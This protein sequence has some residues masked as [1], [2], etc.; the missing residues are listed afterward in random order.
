MRLNILVRTC[1]EKRWKR[2]GTYSS[3]ASYVAKESSAKIR[4]VDRRGTY[5]ISY[6]FTNEKSE[7][8]RRKRKLNSHT[9][10][11]NAGK[12]ESGGS[13]YGLTGGKADGN[14]QLK[15]C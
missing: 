9:Y 14:L 4:V 1:R 6:A 13:V 11:L 8:E 3:S 5:A 10:G 2:L 15:I 7:S 12:I